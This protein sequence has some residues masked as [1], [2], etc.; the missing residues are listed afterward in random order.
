VQET[1]PERDGAGERDR[2]TTDRDQVRTGQRVI[3]ETVGTFFLVMGAAG[4]LVVD[5]VSGGK[6]G[7]APGA[8]VPGLTVLAMILAFGAISG[9]HLNP[10]ITLGF[11]MRGDFPWRRVPVYILAQLVGGLAACA[12]LRVMFGDIA[13][14]GATFPGPRIGDATVFLMELVLTVGLV[15]VAIGTASEGRNLGGLSAVAVGGYVALAGLW[16]SPIS[17]ASMNPGRSLAPQIVTGDLRDAWIYVAAPILGAIIAV[18]IARVI[19][20]SGGE[21]PAKEAAQ[22]SALEPS[23]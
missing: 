18:G 8:V 16:S 17:G 15:S 23:E 20:G 1:L 4:A 6:I 3:A 19:R 9:A 10:A 14:L 13:H 7:R 5:A 21:P 11:A 12:L 2:Q 22:G